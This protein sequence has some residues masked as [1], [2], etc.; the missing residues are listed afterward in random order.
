VTDPSISEQHIT[1][2][3]TARY[4]TLGGSDDRGR[5]IR[6]LW[7]VCH[8]YGQLAA[9]FLRAFTPIATPSRR[10]VA[11]EGL[12]R[13]YLDSNRKAA[14]PDPRIGASWMTREDREH[15]IADQIAYLDAVHDHVRAALE[16]SVVRLRVL[17]FSQGVAT[18]ARWLAYGRARADDVIFWAGSFPAEIELAPDVPAE[19]LDGI[20]EFSHAEI[21]YHFDRVAPASIER[22]AR[23]PRG[24]PRWP[25]VGIF[26]Q[27]ANRLGNRLGVTVVAITG[28]EGR[29]LHVRGLDAVDGTPVLDIKPVMAE[30][31]P[32]GELRQPAWSSELMAGYWRSS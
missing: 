32:R 25:R 2:Q 17:G 12:S 1:V 4:F 26:A 27:R 13:F 28:R 3:R 20:E 5:E 29:V 11:P 8:G 7:I 23:H 14:N 16:P 6:D 30:F 31:L 10:I 9:S 19:A 22:G 21:V 18:V 24:N 15:E